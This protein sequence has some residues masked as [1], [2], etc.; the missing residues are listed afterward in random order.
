MSSR[1]NALKFG[2]AAA[3]LIASV[4]LGVEDAQA[5]PSYP[6]LIPNGTCNT[7]HTAGGGSPRNAFGLD[8]AA[9]GPNWSQL[10]DLDSDGDGFTN[11]EELGDPMGTWMSGDPDPTYVSDP[12]DINDFPMM[13]GE[14]DM[15]SMEEDMG[16]M[17]E[18]MGMM[19]EADMGTPEED[20][21]AGNNT[22]ANNTTANNTSA[23]NSAGNNTSAN[24]STGNNSAGNNT[25]ANNSAGNNSAG[26][27]A[28]ANNSTGNNNAGEADMGVSD[29][30]DD[31]MMDDGGDDEEGCAQSG[32]GA[33]A[34]G[35]LGL[36]GLLGLVGLWRRKR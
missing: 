7:C 14:E 24:N 33:P 2:A 25:S 13:M 5:K 17:E 18:D 31:D 16:T 30:M 9:N 20:M 32:M 11:G 21:G 8:V 6:G 19:P 26:N 35:G 34:G 4:S 29:E 28:T 12:A 15:G 27:N 3:A 22:T 10:Y 36:L 1:H 23:N